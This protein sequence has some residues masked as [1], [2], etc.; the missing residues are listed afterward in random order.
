MKKQKKSLAIE[1]NKKRRVEHEQQRKLKRKLCHIVEQIR[2]GNFRG[3]N[4]SPLL[5]ANWT[6]AKEMLGE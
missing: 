1:R 3:V 4:S 6:L 2:K 5:W